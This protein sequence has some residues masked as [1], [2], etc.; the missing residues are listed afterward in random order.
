LPL[1]FLSCFWVAGIILGLKLN[2]HPLFLLCGLTPLPLIFV[3]KRYKKHLLFASLCIIIML[4][5]VIR[6]ETNLQTLN[7]PDIRLYVTD[8]VVEIRGTI[9]KD[10]DAR[11]NITHLYLQALE[12]DTGEGSREISNMNTVTIFR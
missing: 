5:G 4:C 7:N 9:Y 3:V 12:I 11:E 8:E 6:A 2:I 1:I 10:P